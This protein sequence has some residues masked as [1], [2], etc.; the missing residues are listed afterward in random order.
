MPQSWAH[1]YSRRNETPLINFS[2]YPNRRSEKGGYATV[3]LVST[4]PFAVKAAARKA[5]VLSRDLA[6]NVHWNN[7]AS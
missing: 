5:H 2:Y 6:S 3:A 4:E 7:P 1:S